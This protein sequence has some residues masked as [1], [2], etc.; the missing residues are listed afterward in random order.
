MTG[1]RVAILATAVLVSGCIGQTPPA[2]TPLPPVGDAVTPPDPCSLVIGDSLGIEVQTVTPDT[3]ADGVIQAGDRLV[4]VDGTPLETL[5][6]VRTSITDQPAGTSI[7]IDIERGESALRQT[8]ALAGAPGSTTPRLG[9]TVSEIYPEVS[10]TN[11]EPG[12]PIGPYVRVME[13]GGEFL[14]VDPLGPVAAPLDASIPDNS[15]WHVA[16]GVAYWVE[17]PQTAPRLVDGDG[18]ELNAWETTASP[19]RVIG[20]VGTDLIVVFLDADGVSIRR[21]HPGAETTA[22]T[23][24]PDPDVG[25]PVISYPSPDGSR[26]IIGLG[27]SGTDALRFLLVDAGTGRTVS[28]IEPLA[29]ASLF[30]WFDDSRLVV[31]FGADPLDL[32]DL[33]T[34]DTTPV[35]L[36]AFGT[37]PLR[38]WPVGD[39]VH[40]LA[41]IGSQLLRTTAGDPTLTRPIAAR[42]A[43]GAVDQIGSGD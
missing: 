29:A 3:P 20:I 12:D 38:L 15:F 8:I 27:Q 17:D 34:G 22:W 31:Q 9:V 42:C 6:D 4:A 43:V 39:G 36:P 14:R 10:L 25:L 32:Y 37:V 30:G 11:L 16:G 24:R 13:I 2:R 35:D 7:T 19:A 28:E 33:L 41:D 1:S 5:G 26:L 21:L 40:L 23:L 18:N